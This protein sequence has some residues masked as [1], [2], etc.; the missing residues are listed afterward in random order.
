MDALETPVQF[1]HE[2][3]FV[4]VRPEDSSGQ[5]PEFLLVFRDRMDLP[6][7][8]NLEAVFDPPEER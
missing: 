8:K 7:F 4:S 3:V 6:V 5:C 1:F 2:S